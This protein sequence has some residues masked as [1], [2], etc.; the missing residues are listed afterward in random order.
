MSDSD[1]SSDMNT[2]D[3]Y[4]DEFSDEDAEDVLMYPPSPVPNSGGMMLLC[5]KVKD[6]GFIKL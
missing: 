4:D 6:I 3:S 5:L 2:D 1:D